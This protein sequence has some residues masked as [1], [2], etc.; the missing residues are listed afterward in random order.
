[1]AYRSRYGRRRGRAGS[2][3]RGRKRFSK[4]KAPYNRFTK[5]VGRRM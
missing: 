1:M 2:R 3:R 5:L 4:P